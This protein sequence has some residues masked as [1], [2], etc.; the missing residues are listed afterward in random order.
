VVTPNTKNGICGDIV[1]LQRPD[2]RWE[3]GEEAN[4][5]KIEFQAVLRGAGRGFPVRQ[6]SI[7]R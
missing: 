2:L 6:A 4:A 7:P 1:T 3:I 5:V